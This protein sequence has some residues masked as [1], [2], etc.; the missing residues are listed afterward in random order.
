MGDKNILMVDLVGQYDKIKDEINQNIINSLQ[1][2]K[3]ING[4]IVKE[5]SQNLA[6][7]LNVKHVV[8]CANGT[9]ALQIA[10]MAL[11]LKS[12]DEIICPSWTYISTAE[13]AAIIGVK[14]I[15]CDVDPNTFNVTAEFIEP[16]I[17]KKTKAIVVVHLY[18]QSCDMKPILNLA[19]KHN[20]KVIEDNAQSIG[21]EYSFSNGEKK[22]TGTMGDIG[23]T[24]F[25]PTKNLG[26]YGDGGAI[27]TNDDKL[28]KKIKMIA[29]HGQ[30][31]KY[32]HKTIGC[33]SRLDSIQAEVLNV[34]FK[35]LNDYN[36]ARN[37]M[38][39]NYNKAFKSV[40]QLQIPELNKN[41]THV[42]HQYTLKVLNGKRDDLMKYLEQNK[43]ET[44]VYY[45]IPVHKQKA[46]SNY[47][48]ISLINTDELA[49]SCL[50]LPIHSEIENSSQKYIIDNVLNFFK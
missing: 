34:K 46:F 3:F 45:P 8:P 40:E 50:S 31:K 7:F 4:P 18:G 1:K 20:L 24:S 12:S 14:T 33:N 9:D 11:G 5:F 41:S 28:A 47:S 43:I 19:K 22:Y 48:N 6:N 21:C 16:L 23:T 27:F 10:Y 39:E 37:Q 49:T 36:N 32:H 38:A 26:A 15:F 29:N 42:Y 30:S 35:Y 44:R 2:G 13:A 17:T 25:Y